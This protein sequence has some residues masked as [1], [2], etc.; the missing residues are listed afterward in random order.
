MEN[1]ENKIELDYFYKWNNY[2]IWSK[3]S[4]NKNLNSTRKKTQKNTT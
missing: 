4:W 3:S 1:L 2:G